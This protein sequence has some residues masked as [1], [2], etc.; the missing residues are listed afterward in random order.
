M[1]AS[2]EAGRPY[3]VSEFNQPYPNRQAAELDP[4]LAAFGA[5]QGWDSIMHFAYSHGRGWDNPTPGSFDIN[6]DWTKWPNLGQSAWLFRSGAIAAGTS[7][8]EIAVS[9]ETRMQFTRQRKL[10]AYQ[11]F[12]GANGI[13]PALAFVHPIGLRAAEKPLVQAEAPSSPY[14]SDTGE[15]VYDKMGRTYV[16]RAAKAAAAIGYFTKAE[17]GAMDVELVVSDHGFAT[18]V[19]TSLDDRP[20]SQSRRMLLST[21]GY[22]LGAGQKLGLYAGMKDWWTFPAELG[23]AKPSVDRVAKS[24]V[25]MERV[26]SYVTLHTSSNSLAVYPLD[27]AGG[28]LAALPSKDVVHC[29]VGFRVHLQAEGQTLAP[30]YEWVT[31]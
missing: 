15:L 26:E 12:L 17:A 4:L 13:D 19:L 7:P 23:S 3:T 18:I 11:A 31:Q 30:W 22:T 1:A 24:P 8:V 20:L 14:R 29:T 28:R 27:G 5:F 6:G 9:K 21:P 10:S 25:L 16:I 2:R